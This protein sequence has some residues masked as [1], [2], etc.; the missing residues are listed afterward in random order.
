[1]GVVLKQSVK[2]TIFTYLGVVFGFITTGFLLPRLF[3]TEQVGLLKILVAYSL[4]FAQLGTLGLNGVTTRLFPYFHDPKKGHHGF[5]IIL[6]ITGILGFILTSGFF[7]LL[8]PILFT[9][10]ANKSFLLSDN[11][12]KL[13]VLIFFSLFFSLFDSYYSALY[14]STRG[15]FLKEVLQRVLIII[16]IGVYFLNWINFNV[17][18]WLYVSVLS[19]PT[20]VIVISLILEKHLPLKSDWKFITRPLLVSI[21]TVSLFN[22]L[23]SFSSIL[24]QNVD[25]IMVNSFL[26]LKATGI[27]S[28]AFFFGILVSMPSRAI[29]K[30]SNIVAAN[31]WKDNDMKTIKDLYY[32]SCLNLFIIGTLLFVGLWAN[33]DNVFRILP[34]QYVAG[35]WVIFFIGIGSLID[36]T[37]GVNSSILGNSAYYKV[38]TLFML[39]LSVFVVVTNYIFIPIYGLTGAA[40]A[41]ALSLTI[42]NIL[43][44]LYLFYKFHLQPFSLRFIVVI[45]LGLVSYFISTLIP[46]NSNYII[47]IL[48]RGSTI[49][50]IYMVPVYFFKVSHDITEKIN[51]FFGK[52]KIGK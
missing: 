41:S 25:A 21:V 16:S 6:L 44:Y 49:V 40:M 43:R 8:K 10:I 46:S 7:F 39:I 24:I 27:Y 51:D 13:F 48:V 34:D 26:G 4:L 11:L 30:I 23:N 42:V 15:T 36:M 32:K 35:K 47:D 38:Q 14:N 1:M 45:F 28:I 18:L 3:S 52:I 29:V 2:G 19:L 5:V 37:T 20:I 17:F 22:I 33:I 12:D 9:S 31:A 50:L